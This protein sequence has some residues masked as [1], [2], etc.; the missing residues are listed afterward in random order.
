MLALMSLTPSVITVNRGTGAGGFSLIQRLPTH[1]TSEQAQLLPVRLR[2]GEMIGGQLRAA[3]VEA[4]LLAGDLES[5]PDHPDHRPGALHP[6]APLRVVVAPA[7]H[8]ADQGEDLAI[9]IRIIR[10]QPFAEEIA[11]FEREP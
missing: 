3:L 8:V 6:R 4:E 11:D 1:K 9:A 7:A 2:F 10:H 5:S